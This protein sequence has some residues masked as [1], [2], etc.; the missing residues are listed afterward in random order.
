MAIYDQIGG[1][2][3]FTAAVDDFYVRVL[4]DPDL[5]SYFDGIEMARLKAHQRAFLAAALGGPEQY[6]GRSMREAHA[7]LAVT[8]EAFAKVVAHLVATLKKLGVDGDTIAAIGAKLAP[9]EDDIVAQ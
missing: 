3:S 1:A 9:L 7:A 2:P 5:R 6:E 8:P 4:E